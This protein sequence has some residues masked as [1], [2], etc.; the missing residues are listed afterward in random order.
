MKADSQGP[1]ALR[2]YRQTTETW[3]LRIIKGSST[4]RALRLPRSDNFSLKHPSNCRETICQV[5]PYL[6]QGG[7]THVKVTNESVGGFV[8]L[9]FAGIPVEAA[10]SSGGS[11]RSFRTDCACRGFAAL[12]TPGA[13][14][15]QQGALRGAERGGW[16]SIGANVLLGHIEDRQFNFIFNSAADASR[17]SRN[18]HECVTRQWD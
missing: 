11:G 16:T 7:R 12:Y 6:W 15:G 9:P 17:Y 2:S 14:V 10:R 18:F 5:C 13:P 8:F 4:A 1:S 3:S